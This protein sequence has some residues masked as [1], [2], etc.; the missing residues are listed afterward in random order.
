MTEVKMIKQEIKE[1][2]EDNSTDINEHNITEIINLKEHSRPM[3]DLPSLVEEDINIL[4]LHYPCNGK[5]ENITGHC[6]TR[7]DFLTCNFKKRKAIYKPKI[8]AC[9]PGKFS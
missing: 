6:N 8:I 1:I 9:I 3:V 5:A 7:N 2:K 4:L